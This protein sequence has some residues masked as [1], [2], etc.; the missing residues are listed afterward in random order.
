MYMVVMRSGQCFQS[1]D[2]R[3]STKELA[4][5]LIAGKVSKYFKDKFDHLMIPLNNSQKI[6][7]LGS[8]RDLSNF[9]PPEYTEIDPE[10]ATQKVVDSDFDFFFVHFE[11]NQ[12][13]ISNDGKNVVTLASN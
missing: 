1:R 13:K 4:K 11:H 9:L 2:W 5:H 8:A 3:I 12:H 10:K 6:L 7:I